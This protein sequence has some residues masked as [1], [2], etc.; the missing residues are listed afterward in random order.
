[1]SET[2]GH[3]MS[4]GL[5][6][7]YRSF[8]KAGGQDSSRLPLIVV[9]GLSYF[10]YDWIDIARALASDRQ[11]VA[12][13]MRGFGASDWSPEKDYSIAANARDLIAVIDHFNWKRA[14]LV[15]HSMGGRYC[16]FAAAEHPA[17][18]AGLVSVDFAPANAP[19]GAARVA[20]TVGG[21]PDD[22]ASIDEAMAYFGT[23][24]H[25]PSGR[26]R[27]E[28][29]LEPVGGRFR[30]RRD[31]VFRDQFRKILETGERPKS[32]VDMWE[33]L[34]RVPCPILVLRGTRSDMF[35]P[36]IAAQFRA[37]KP[38][39]RFVEIE[40]GH[41]IGGEQPDRLVAEVREFLSDLP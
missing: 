31:P 5:R 39:A 33:V 29:Y 26:S 18:I 2:Q 37:A 6:I 3:V 27:Y 7:A 16:T 11:V 13:D 17:R 15:G 40:A 38:D 8:G 22:F 25:S 30:I 14:V 9:H 36:E 35:S 34:R 20:Q 1:M 12:I 41:N 21:L 4:E 24:A 23:D 28:H 10:S 32:P 19:Q